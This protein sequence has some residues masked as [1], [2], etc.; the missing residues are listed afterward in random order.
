MMS[1]SPTSKW[2]LFAV[3]LPLFAFVWMQYAG[4][5]PGMTSKSAP[6]DGRRFSAELARTLS[7]GLVDLP[8]Q[9]ELQSA[10]VRHVL[11]LAPVG[12]TTTDL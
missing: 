10:P 3:F 8:H 7:Y 5:S 12:R 6:L 9:S 4:I 2:W 1:N 11:S